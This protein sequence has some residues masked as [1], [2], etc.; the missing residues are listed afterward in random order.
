MCGDYDSVIGMKK[1]PAVLKF[2]RK[3]PG[4]KLSPAE[5]PGTLCA[6]FVETDDRTGLAKRIE[7]VR[8]GGRLAQALPSP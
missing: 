4:E 7:P 8:V 2:T 1:E 6:V 5:G 3:L